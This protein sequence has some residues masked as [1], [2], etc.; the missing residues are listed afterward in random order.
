MVTY[1]RAR[2][3]DYICVDAG[4]FANLRESYRLSRRSARIAAGIA[5]NS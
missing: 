2:T 5:L 3:R 1:V 4:I